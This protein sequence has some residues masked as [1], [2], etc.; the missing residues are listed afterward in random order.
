MTSGKDGQSSPEFQ[1]FMILYAESPANRPA[2]HNFLSPV[3]FHD[4]PM[5]LD[6]FCWVTIGGDRVED[7]AIVERAGEGRD[8]V[9]RPV[10]PVLEEAAARDLDT[11]SNTSCHALS[12]DCRCCP[13]AM[14]LG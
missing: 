1:L 6:F 5:P 3:D 2:S 10:G 8:V 11:D 4:T 9:E 13:R 7:A 12:L 14:R